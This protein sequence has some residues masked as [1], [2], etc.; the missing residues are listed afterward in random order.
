MTTLSISKTT[1]LSEI[2]GG[3]ND[4]SYEIETVEYEIGEDATY[5]RLKSDTP[6]ID[7][8]EYE[9]SETVYTVPWAR[10]VV[11]D[12]TP[13]VCNGKNGLEIS[14]GFAFGEIN[15]ITVKGDVSNSGAEHAVHC[16]R[17]AVHRRQI[18]DH[19]LWSRPLF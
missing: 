7:Y 10:K 19:W 5:L 11:F 12:F 17:R 14:E 3:T 18:R 9:G 2:S 1:A 8:S 13:S 15:G 4:G 16:G 6:L